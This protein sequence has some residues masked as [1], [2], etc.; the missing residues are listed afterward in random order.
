MSQTTEKPSSPQINAS[1]HSTIP[2][3]NT[4]IPPPPIAPTMN[5][6]H[7]ED[8]TYTWDRSN[9]DDWPQVKI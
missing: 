8:G 4:T 6:M 5:E 3:M 7:D 9:V 1:N 2:G